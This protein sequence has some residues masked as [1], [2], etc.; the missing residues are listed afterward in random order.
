MSQPEQQWYFI[1]V[2]NQERY[3]PYSA[4]QLEGFVRSGS[5]TRETMIWTEAL[6]D[7]WIPATNV[8]GLFPAEGDIAAQPTPTAPAGRPKLLTGTPAGS[9]RPL[10][11]A[12]PLR[13]QPLQAQPLQ[14]APVQAAP[15]QAAPVQAAPVQAAPAPLVAAVQQA[16]APVQPAAPQRQ[17]VPGLIPSSMP[18]TA[19]PAATAARTASPIPGQAIVGHIAPGEPF[20][21]PPATKASFGRWMGLFGG[22]LLLGLIALLSLGAAASKS[23]AGAG[24]FGILATIGAYGL[25]TWAGVLA[26]MYLYRAW[27]LIQPGNVRTTPGKAIG[28]L[29]IP[30]YN[31]YWMFIAVGA[32]P[33]DW[34]RVMS[35]HPNLNQA[36]RLSTGL[37]ITSLFV[38][39]VGIFWIASMCKAINFMGRLHL[40]P[41]AGSGG[42]LGGPA[43]GGASP[44]PQAGGG[45][46]LY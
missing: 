45:I 31:I 10:T 33:A 20:P 15:V 37:A 6:Q 23:S 1:S 44:Q 32:L 21:V 18:G 19:Q 38:P 36:P 8:E 14:A 27:K 5:I 28:F 12:A 41:G 11:Q 26:Y 9:P 35:S 4:E 40:N 30:F 42:I 3:G 7:Q 25:V 46:R 24:V 22:G 43:S 39:I 34:N 2:V 29:F 17:A 16:P 13:A